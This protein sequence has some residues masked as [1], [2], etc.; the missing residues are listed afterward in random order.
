MTGVQTCAL[1]IYLI[2]GKI[3]LINFMYTSCELWCPR[4]TA[5]LAKVQKMLGDRVGRDIFMYSIT[6]DPANDTPEVLTDYA[7]KA[8]VGPGWTFLTGN[9]EAIKK[10]RR[11]LGVYNRNPVI[12]ADITQHGGLVVYGNDA[13]DRWAAISGLNKPEVIV[14]AVLRVAEPGHP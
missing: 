7:K 13:L 8:G 14:R 2:K 11:K 9:E 12:D 4:S 10:L 5:K 3:S 6:L 1:P